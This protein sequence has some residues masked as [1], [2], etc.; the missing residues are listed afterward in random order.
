KHSIFELHFQCTTC[1]RF[2]CSVCYKSVSSDVCP[3][4]NG[5]LVPVPRI[6]KKRDVDSLVTKGSSVSSISGYYK[7][8]REKLSKNGLKSVTSS[9]ASD[10][11]KLNKRRWNLSKFKDQTKSFWEFRKQERAIDKHKRNIIDT[12][13]MIHEV[14]EID[15]IPL[16]RIAKINKI[17][18]S[19]VNSILRRL[20]ETQHIQGFLDTSGTYDTTTDDFLVIRSNKIKCYFHEA[21][22]S[23]SDPH[24]K[25]I[26]C[27]RSF[28]IDCHSTMSDQGVS[29]CVFCGGDLQ[30]EMD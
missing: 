17:D 21:E 30:Q 3:Y 7:Q 11:K 20:I 19:I 4:C 29:N 24:F 18:I 15:Q 28:C 10:F 8:Q 13:T 9:L 5:E 12:I 6:F 27:F 22:I 1:L 26:S 23:L 16:E 14:E 25:C 2:T